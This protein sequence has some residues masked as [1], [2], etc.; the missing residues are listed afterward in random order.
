MFSATF[1]P[2]D[3]KLSIICFP[4]LAFNLI[5]DSYSRFATATVTKPFAPSLAISTDGV[6]QAVL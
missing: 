6:C 4:T 5:G 2:W 3:P 1:N